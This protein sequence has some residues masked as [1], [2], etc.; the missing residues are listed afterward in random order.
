[1]GSASTSLCV[2]L[3]VGHSVCLSVDIMLVFGLRLKYLSNVFLK[4]LLKSYWLE[5]SHLKIIISLDC[6]SKKL[7]KP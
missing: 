4:H 3:L 1:M 6:S 2:C 5:L 7:R